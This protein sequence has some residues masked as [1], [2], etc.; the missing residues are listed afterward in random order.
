MIIQVTQT[1]SLYITPEIIQDI[2]ADQ[3]RFMLLKINISIKG[4][5]GSQINL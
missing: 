4:S 2:C 3:P 1:K 5:I